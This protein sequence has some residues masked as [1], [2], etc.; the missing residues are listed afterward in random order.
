[1]HHCQRLLHSTLIKQ[2]RAGIENR[3][4]I[5]G[6]FWEYSKQKTL[7]VHRT[8]LSALLVAGGEH[9]GKGMALKSDLKHIC[10]ALR[11]GD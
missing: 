2:R 6:P 9:L 11:L 3:S 7:R 5:R 10:A 1:M 8:S 4:T